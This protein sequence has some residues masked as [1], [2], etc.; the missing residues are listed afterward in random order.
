[1]YPDVLEQEELFQ[2]CMVHFQMKVVLYSYKQCCVE[3]FSF[4]FITLAFLMLGISKGEGEDFEDF[5]F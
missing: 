2:G 5:K 4:Y 1:M 3:R